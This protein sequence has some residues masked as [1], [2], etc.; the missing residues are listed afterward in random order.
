MT[1]QD[2]CELAIIKGFTY[3]QDS[4]DVIGPRGNVIIAKDNKGY[5][6]IQLY[7]NRKPY[8]LLAHQFAFYF[9]Y[10]KTVDYIDHIDNNPLN[11]RIKNLRAVNHQQNMW[12]QKKSKGYSWN[13]NKNKW[14]AR[15]SINGKTKYLGYFDKEDDARQAYLKAK[16]NYHIIKNPHIEG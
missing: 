13:K 4:G 8:H 10:G 12:N 11:N 1:R 9:I 5:I 14:M 3:N 16:E 7:V 2:K 6:R 15:I